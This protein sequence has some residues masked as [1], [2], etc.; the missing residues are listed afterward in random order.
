MYTNIDGIAALVASAMVGAV[1]ANRKAFIE[2][3]EFESI[4]ESWFDMVAA[5]QIPQ[6]AYTDTYQ[7]VYNHPEVQMALSV[8]K[9]MVAEERQVAADNVIYHEN[10]MR[11][12]GLSQKD[13]L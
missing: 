7:A 6:W 10:P 1:D 11:Y 3:D 13:F 8:I 9:E 4:F 5:P 12:Y 2:M